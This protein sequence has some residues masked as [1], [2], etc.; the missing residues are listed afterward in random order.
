[1]IPFLNATDVAVNKSIIKAMRRNFTSFGSSKY[2][3]A[4]NTNKANR[5]RGAIFDERNDETFSYP[6]V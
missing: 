5:I 3:K 4:F 2:V 6:L 1:M